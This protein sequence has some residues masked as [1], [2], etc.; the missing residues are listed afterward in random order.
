MLSTPSLKIVILFVLL[1]ATFLFSLLPLIALKLS[2]Q[3][4]LE[5]HH[6]RL[7][8]LVVSILS[9]FAAGVFIG[10]CLLDLFPEVQSK[11]NDVLQTAGINTSFPVAEFVIVIGFLLLLIVE[12]FVL[13]WKAG[14]TSSGELAP[15]MN[16]CDSLSSS[17]SS[18][19]GPPPPPPQTRA[20]AHGYGSGDH[21]TA[22]VANNFDALDN[23]EPETEQ[24]ED[25]STEQ[26]YS[27]PSSHS[28]VRSLVLVIALSMHSLFEGL[29]IGLQPTFDDTLQ[30]FGALALHKCVLA[31][32]LGLNMVQ[33][34]LGT[35]A[36]IISAVSFSL[37][38]PIGTA[39]GIAISDM[40]AD[41]M[42]ANSTIGALQG[43][44]CGTFI[45]IIFFEIL[46]HEFMK[47]R[48]Q[49]CPDRMLKVLFLLI[50]FSV[51]VGVVFLDPNA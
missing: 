51:I 30:L 23:M 50:G 22:S 45:Y 12:Q 40:S 11:I 24:G 17:Y 19:V 4:R 13:N 35:R 37:A 26:I 31:F 9:C 15:L 42:A 7:C 43:L 25:R 16:D 14:M 47:K 6:R 32:S 39:V 21:L 41:S 38:S 1:V 8:R 48:A 18:S 27:D 46:P 10:V 29:A 3:H 28:V 36:V 33:S 49:M 5:S 2:R 34:K 44:A 20:P